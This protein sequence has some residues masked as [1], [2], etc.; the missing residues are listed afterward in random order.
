[1]P[2]RSRARSSAITT[3]TAA[4]RGRWSPRPA[5]SSTVK[6]PSSACTRW[7]RPSSPLPARVGAARALVGDLD[8]E[9]VV[10]ALDARR[11]PAS[12]CR[13][14]RRWSAPRRRRSRPPSRP[15][16][17]GGRRARV[18][19]A[20]GISARRPSPSTAAARPRSAS[21]GGAIPRARSRSSAIAGPASSR[22]W[23]T[24]SAT[25][26][27]SASLSSARPSRMLSATSRACAPS[28]RS[29]SIRR[30]SAAWTSSAPRRVR[31]S[32]STR[33][34]SCASRRAGALAEEQR[35]RGVGHRQ[36]RAR[37][38]SARSSRSPTGPRRRPDADEQRRGIALDRSRRRGSGA[39]FS[40][41]RTPAA[42]RWA[43]PGRATP[44]TG[45][46]GPTGRSAQISVTSEAGDRREGGLPRQRRR[47]RAGFDTG[48]WSAIR[49]PATSTAPR[50]ASA[51]N[52]RPLHRQR[53][54]RAARSPPA[55]RRRGRSSRRAGSRPRGR[56]PAA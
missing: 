51:A 22:A 14:W 32:S 46:N 42:G 29:R 23:R 1:M 34:S 55:A 41:R 44:S 33:S 7:R 31:V 13:A 10:L 16:A 11:G 43:G 27:W 26:G 18:S 5:G 4:P 15:P 3:R 24:S 25:S 19:T 47:S 35:V 38:T 54:R 49:R 37:A 28:C 12:P 50:L 45:Q 30:S 21:T 20:T 17:A 56:S 53:G 6:R 8:D 36:R 52:P 39:G 40:P 2:S 48:R 9:H